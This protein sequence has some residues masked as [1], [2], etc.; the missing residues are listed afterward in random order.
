[1]EHQSPGS[2][3]AAQVAFAADLLRSSR[4]TA[5]GVL[6]GSLGG[7]VQQTSGGELWPGSPALVFN[8]ENPTWRWTFG[9]F[10]PIF[11][12]IFIFFVSLFEVFWDYLGISGLERIGVVVM[13]LEIRGHVL[14]ADKPLSVCNAMF[15]WVRGSNLEKD[16]SFDLKFEKMLIADQ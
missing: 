13:A 2:A 5:G 8:R 11:L 1:M 10:D 15:S 6:A 12:Y 4:S 9:L 16:L 14:E 7:Q 3:V